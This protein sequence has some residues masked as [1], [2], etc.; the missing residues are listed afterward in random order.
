MLTPRVAFFALLAVYLAL[1]ALFAALTPAWQAP[2]EPAHYNVLRQLHAAAPPRCCPIIE[3]GDWDQ[4]L[5]SRLTRER[6]AGATAETLATL[7]YEDHQPPLYYLLAT[8]VYGWSDGS[9]VALRLF[10]ALLGA[11]VVCCAWLLA[12]AAL[13]DRPWLAL[14]AAAFVAFLPQHL[15]MMS[16]VNNDSLT[17]ALIGLALV[18]L[19]RWLLDD[20]AALQRMARMLLLLSLPVCALL[21]LYG[22]IPV[23]AALVFL[24]L[25]GA[26]YGLWRAG[27]HDLWPL[28]FMGMLAGLLL[29]TKAGGY[30][31]AGLLPLVFLL[32]LRGNPGARRLLPAGLFCLLLPALLTGALW[33]ARNLGVYGWPDLLG[34]A[35]HDRVVVGQLRTAQ[36]I[37]D[38]GPLA[39]LERILRVTFVSFWGQFGWMA[40]PLQGSLLLLPLALSLAGLSGALAARRESPDPGLRLLWQALWLVIVLTALAYLYYNLE[41]VQW[42]GRYLYPALLPLA[43]LLV[44]GLDV[45]RERL[46]PDRLHW[47]AAAAVCVL[48]PFDLYLLLRV[49]R[50]LLSA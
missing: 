10:S 17:E 48:A 23:A 31:V 22:L 7:Q 49:I 2:D 9:L 50:P 6:F 37:A 46:L 25:A 42:Q 21:L 35:A 5:L 39:W 8:L 34:L 33:W 12:Q 15:A 18:A 32:R 40:L 28:W 24:A 27:R 43:L 20:Q 41:F 19:A 3:P 11:V 4:A 36:L 1:A 45:W 29:V 13:P 14:A 38:V 47:L 44:R 30:F 26:G 16:A